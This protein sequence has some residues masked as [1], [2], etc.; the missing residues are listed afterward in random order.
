MF[1]QGL[2]LLSIPESVFVKFNEL[3]S[4]FYNSDQSDDESSILSFMYEEC[5]FGIEYK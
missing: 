5:I 4:I 3:L 1:S 2:G